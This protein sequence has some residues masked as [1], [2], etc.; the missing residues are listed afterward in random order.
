[1]H[2]ALLA[3]SWIGGGGKK[4]HTRRA[5]AQ[6]QAHRWQEEEEEEGDLSWLGF[7]SPSPRSLLL[8]S[9]PALLQSQPGAHSVKYRRKGSRESLYPLFCVRSDDIALLLAPGRDKSKEEKVRH[10][11]SPFFFS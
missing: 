10:T 11:H 3:P 9:S 5:L 1:M 8:S 7:K 2:A 4:T 6:N